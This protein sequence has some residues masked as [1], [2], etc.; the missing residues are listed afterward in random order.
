MPLS[1]ATFRALAESRKVIH[2]EGV[3]M[4][5]DLNLKAEL[6]ITD[7]GRKRFEAAGLRSQSGAPIEVSVKY[8]I[9]IEQGVR[10]CDDPIEID[11]PSRAARLP[12]TCDHMIVIAELQ[13]ERMTGRIHTECDAGVVSVDAGHRGTVI[14]ADGC[15]VCDCVEA[16]LSTG[17]CVVYQRNKDE[18]V[19]STDDNGNAWLT[20]TVVTRPAPLR[21]ISRNG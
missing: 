9:E 2:G 3:G 18:I 6:A 13:R 16:N 14:D 19:V 5:R 11:N 7:D 8:P 12:K 20:M 17:D 21:F 4:A 10:R 1:E 15:E